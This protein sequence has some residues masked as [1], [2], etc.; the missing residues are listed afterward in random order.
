MIVSMED[1]MDISFD[2]PDRIMRLPEVIRE[3]GKCRAGIYAEIKAGEFPPQFRI[4][5]RAVGWSHRAIQ[6]YIRAKITGTDYSATGASKANHKAKG[7]RPLEDG[8]K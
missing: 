8:S 6:A 2:M 1:S 4:G 5:K 7:G 3:T